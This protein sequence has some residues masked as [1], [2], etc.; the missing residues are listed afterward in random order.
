MRAVHTATHGNTAATHGNTAA[1]HGN[2]AATHGNTAATH[3]NTAA[4]PTM[5][6]TEHFR[7]MTYTPLPS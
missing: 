5:L 3:G 2:T 4:T 7:V 6:E 1:T